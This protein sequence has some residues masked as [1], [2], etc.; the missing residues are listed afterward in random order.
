[1]ASSY[2]VAGVAE[3]VGRVTATALTATRPHRLPVARGAAVAGEALEV[4]VAGALPR[5]GVTL[6]G[7]G[8]VRR[9]GA[10]WWVQDQETASLRT[11]ALNTFCPQ[12]GPETPTET[13]M[14]F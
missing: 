12:T 13:L 1:M 8:A 7:A 4:G 2:L 6:G 11:T 9:A 3:R 5:H 14:H 10:L